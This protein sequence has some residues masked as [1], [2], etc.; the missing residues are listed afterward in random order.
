[1]TTANAIFYAIYI[2]LVIGIYI[3]WVIGE[4]I[5][6]KRQK[7]EWNKMMK[8]KS[9]VIYIPMHYIMRIAWEVKRR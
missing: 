3:L 4:R 5:E 2:P 8:E 6:K 1:M 7:M 9:G